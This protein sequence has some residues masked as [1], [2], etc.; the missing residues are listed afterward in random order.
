MQENLNKKE[1]L[2]EK[3]SLNQSP[4]LKHGIEKYLGIFYA[5]INALI[6]TASEVFFKKADF[7]NGAE[8]TLVK[9]SLQFLILL[10]AMLVT[11]RSLLGPNEQRL[12]LSL[13]GFYFAFTV[14]TGLMALTF[15][16]PTDLIPLRKTSIILVAIASR[17]LLN[18]KLNFTH[19]LA[20]IL[21]ITGKFIKIK[22][23]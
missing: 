1:I 16:N 9:F 10:I 2:E 17:F 23:F 20:I 21:T 19:I 4:V 11:K 13:Q 3:N 18:E 7:F 14:L 8:K 5:L 22:Y 15:I 6:F 12:A